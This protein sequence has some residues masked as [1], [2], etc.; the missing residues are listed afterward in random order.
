MRYLIKGKAKTDGHWKNVTATF[1]NDTLDE[2]IERFVKRFKRV[3]IP[4]DMVKVE[5]AYVQVLGD[6]WRL[7]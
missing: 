4:G 6:G 1:N 3:E 2:A 5:A 7:E